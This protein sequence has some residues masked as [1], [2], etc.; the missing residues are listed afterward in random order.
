MSK[1]ALLSP[2][3]WLRQ[4]APHSPALPA[5][6]G[7][8]VEARGVAFSEQGVL[9]DSLALLDR[10]GADADTLQAAMLYAAGPEVEAKPPWSVSASVRTLLEGLHEAEKVW[11]LWG[12][13]GARSSAEGLRRLLLAIIRDLR[14]V[15]IL[16]ARQLAKMRAASELDEDSRRRLAQLSADIHAP[17]ANRL[18]IWQLKWEMED[19][20]FR[21]LQPDT[22]RR[23][24]KLL[25]EKRGDRERFIEDAKARLRAALA[26]AGIRAEVAGRPKHIY[27]IWKKMQ[28]KD[29]PF[30]D[31]YDIRAVRVLVDDL[32]ACYAALGAAHS[33]WT[34]IASEFDDYIA[35]PKGNNYRSLHTATP[36]SNARSPG[37]ASCWKAR[38]AR[39]TRRCWPGCRPS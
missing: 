24:A 19:L 18:G 32:T 38:R 11:A 14:V 33:L 7:A 17:L 12:E 36:S 16:L 10:L 9:T 2:L 4:R 1:P 35:N 34:P 6:V 13:R 5:E 15:L 8:W 3:D 23:I 37:C 28:R 20:A 27:S 21:Y 39:R 31:L 25:D 30:S 26:E 29:V 22:Y